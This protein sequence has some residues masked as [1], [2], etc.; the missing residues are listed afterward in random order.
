MVAKTIELAL[1][2]AFE[3]TLSGVSA[4][5]LTAATAEAKL[6]V[7]VACVKSVNNRF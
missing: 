3:V 5:S 1:A 4:T 6:L 2:A 7:Y